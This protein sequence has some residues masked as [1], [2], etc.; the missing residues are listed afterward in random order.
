MTQ[1]LSL[2]SCIDSLTGQASTGIVCPEWG[3][4]SP[5]TTKETQRQVKRCVDDWMVQTDGMGFNVKGGKLA[6]CRRKKAPVKAVSGSW[7]TNPPRFLFRPGLSLKGTSIM[8]HDSLPSIPRDLLQ[9]HTF[10]ISGAI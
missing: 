4:D 7:E 5:N 6:I 3:K 10:A 8:S 2:I 1:E 9:A